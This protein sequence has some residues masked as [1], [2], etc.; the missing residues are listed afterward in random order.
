MGPPLVVP[1]WELP[2][3]KLSINISLVHLEITIQTQFCNNF[4]ISRFY[5]SG[6]LW[7]YSSIITANRHVS[8]LFISLYVPIHAFSVWV[9]FIS[10]SGWSSW[11]IS[12]AEY[13]M[14]IP[15]PI[16]KDAAM[17]AAKICNQNLRFDGPFARL[18]LTYLRP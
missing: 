7:R 4:V 2:K 3:N 10:L 5:W 9:G 14:E 1:C 12:T 17:T 8:D 6:G 16:W 15:F 13:A 18:T 11:A